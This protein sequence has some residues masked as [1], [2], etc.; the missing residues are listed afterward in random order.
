[1]FLDLGRYAEALD[2]V[3]QVLAEDVENVDA[4]RLRG[5]ILHRSGRHSEAFTAYNQ[6]IRILD[7]RYQQV[8]ALAQLRISQTYLDRDRR[9]PQQICHDRAR[10]F[11]PAEV[12]FCARLNYLPPE[13]PFI[14]SPATNH[15][16][17]EPLW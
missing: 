1:L 7:Q 10:Y 12:A 14:P 9:S 5:L 15:D 4:W 6:A 3:N 16:V 11:T 8:N 13:I 2:R 17:L